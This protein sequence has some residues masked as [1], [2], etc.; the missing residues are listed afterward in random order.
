MMNEDDKRRALELVAKVPIDERGRRSW[1]QAPDIA[2]QVAAIV[3]RSG[4]GICEAESMLGMGRSTMSKFLRG[5]NSSG[6]RC[7]AITGAM[8]R[9]GI[10]P[11]GDE[12]YVLSR[13]NADRRP[14]SLATPSVGD[15]AITV[16]SGV[17]PVMM[18][19]DANKVLHDTPEKAAQANVHVERGKAARRF[20]DFV[21]KQSGGLMTFDEMAAAFVMDEAVPFMVALLN[22][23]AF[24]A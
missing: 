1:Q 18:Y 9:E 13:R 20:A 2:G 7:P 15:I 23:R 24:A 19:R 4:I 10:E 8:R 12:R 22:G 21:D 16:P 14:R 6:E 11:I 3:I 5:R 17:E